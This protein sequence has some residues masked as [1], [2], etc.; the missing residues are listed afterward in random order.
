[1]RKYFVN[2]WKL[3]V[4]LLIMLPIR[5][6]EGK[7][8]EHLE[9][10]PQKIRIAF[11]QQ[12]LSAVEHQL[13]RNIMIEGHWS[14]NILIS[15]DSYQTL[16][17]LGEFKVINRD[18]EVSVMHYLEMI[19]GMITRIGGDIAK[20]ILERCKH[21]LSAIS[22]EEIVSSAHIKTLVHWIEALQNE[23]STP[24]NLTNTFH[25]KSSDK[26]LKTYNQLQ[27]HYPNHISF[28]TAQHS[29]FLA[30]SIIA[31]NVLKKF[32][33]GK[34]SDSYLYNIHL[35]R[36]PFVGLPKNL[37]ELFKAYP[38]KEDYD[39]ASDLVANA[40][41]SVSPSLKEAES[42]ESAW[43]IFENNERK[44]DVTI[45][46]NQIFES[47]QVSPVHFRNRMKLLL[48]DAPKSNKGLIYNFFIPK[49]APLHKAIYLSYPYGIPKGDPLSKS[50]VLDFYEQ[51]RQDTVEEEDSQLRFLPSAL[52]SANN[53]DLDQIKSYRF[54]TI[55]QGKLKDYAQKIE[56]VVNQIFEDHL[57]EMLQLAALAS[58]TEALQDPIK[59]QLG[60][61][62]LCYRHLCRR[63][64]QL[65]L[66]YWHRIDD[67]NTHKFSSLCGIIA[68]LLKK[69][70]TEAYHYFQQYEEQ[71]IHK[72][73]LI[74]R[75]ALSYI[76]NENI[77]MFDFMLS[78]LTESNLK[79][80]LLFL[81]SSRYPEKYA[82]VSI[83]EEMESLMSDDDLINMAAIS[84]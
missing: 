56:S 65:A 25:A 2:S 80:F 62:K 29:K 78:K 9:S 34:Y 63:D 74:T 84:E 26:I 82:R 55:P 53:F 76:E 71:L 52:I 40:L 67:Q 77:S 70:I 54:T 59:K 19:E 3:L 15:M 5:G 32:N 61:Q 42:E 33:P 31:V 49:E 66:Y 20:E 30:Y 28:S 36:Y 41:I 7:P 44:T 17:N 47:E 45:Y 68:C 83:P 73:Q 69:N 81:A 10:Y 79:S 48:N 4:V 23:L 16:I 39:T 57:E 11:M 6:V 24:V 64:L 14:E 51:Y 12:F 46:L 21:H 13:L 22:R 60:Y 58:E 38:V 75:F 18:A 35:L 1:L 8:L 43:A 37:E 27:T 72:E 50:N